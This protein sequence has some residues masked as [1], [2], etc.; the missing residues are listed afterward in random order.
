MKDTY[1]V[2]V[3]IFPNSKTYVGLTKQNVED[4][5]NKGEGYKTQPVYEAIMRF[6]WDNIEH[7]VIKDNLTKEEAQELE[8]STIKEFDSINYGYNVPKEEE[9][10]V[11]LG[12]ILN[13]MDNYIHLTN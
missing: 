6:G 2:Y 5:W 1:S 7:I 3:H 9:R 12:A 11:F 10:V 8:K 13:I 4:R